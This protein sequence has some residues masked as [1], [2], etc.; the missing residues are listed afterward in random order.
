MYLVRGAACPRS[1]VHVAP[2]PQP[3]CSC[4]RKRG[5][6]RHRAHALNTAER[7]SS[8]AA[9]PSVSRR[10]VCDRCL[11]LLAAG[12]WCSWCMPTSSTRPR[13][14]SCCCKSQL[15]W[16][17]HTH[18]RVVA[19]PSAVCIPAL[20]PAGASLQARDLRRLRLFHRVPRRGRQ[21]LPLLCDHLLQVGRDPGLRQ[22]G[23]DAAL[24]AAMEAGRQTAQGAESPPSVSLRR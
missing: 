18:H 5:L 11:G 12:T 22:V 16:H 8:I 14:S 21:A 6:A 2:T 15:C 19:R 23:A 4:A 13:R 7:V 1:F 17:W 10:H 24:P 9:D 3:E 20:V